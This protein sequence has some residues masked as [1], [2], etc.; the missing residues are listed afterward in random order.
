MDHV[1]PDIIFLGIQSGIEAV[2][3]KSSNI[4]EE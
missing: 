2:N 4:Q 1:F 3:E